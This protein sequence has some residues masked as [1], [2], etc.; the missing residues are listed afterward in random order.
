VGKTGV[1]TAIRSVDGLVEVTWDAQ[2]WTI[3]GG[4]AWQDSPNLEVN[5]IEGAT[6]V[7]AGTAEIESFTSAVHAGY[8]ELIGP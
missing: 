5:Q 7:S 4:Y 1:I 6:S 8:L 3:H 2:Q